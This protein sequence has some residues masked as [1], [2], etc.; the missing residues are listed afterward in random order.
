MSA[1][2]E[3]GTSLTTTK[4]VRRDVH[5]RAEDQDTRAPDVFLEDGNADEEAEELSQA[6]TFVS[7]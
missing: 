6:R 5:I 4:L 3:G 2:P 7:S 1:R